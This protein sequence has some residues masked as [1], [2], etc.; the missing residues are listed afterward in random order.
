MIRDPRRLPYGA[1][2]QREAKEAWSSLLLLA[3]AVKR[4][5]QPS[6]R[7]LLTAKGLGQRSAKTQI[8][9]NEMRR[10]RGLREMPKGRLEDEV[11]TVVQ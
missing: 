3:D 1:V 5:E 11:D 4:N 2:P 10:R 9:G 7:R 8:G 6:R